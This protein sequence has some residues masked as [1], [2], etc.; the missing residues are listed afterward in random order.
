M[1]FKTALLVASFLSLPALAQAPIKTVRVERIET[2]C[3]HDSQSTADLVT[4]KVISHLVAHG[5]TVLDGESDHA[6]DSI[7]HVT[8]VS[9]PNGTLQG[10]A[11]L[12]DAAG[13]VVWAG[14][15]RTAPFTRSASSSFAESIAKQV[16]EYLARQK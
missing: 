13:K 11:R 14:E 4:A 3:C 6:T 16:E 2:L 9:N 15:A 10:P 1:N 12:T 8:F 7:L 5:V